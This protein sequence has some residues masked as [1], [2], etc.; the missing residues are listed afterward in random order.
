MRLQPPMDLAGQRIA[1]NICYEDLFGAEIIEAWHDPRRAPTILL[2]LSNLAWFGDSIALPQHLHAS[3]M[4]ARETGRPVLRSTNTGA[5]AI[6][7]ARGRITGR[8][9]YNTADVLDGVVQG[10][11]GDTPFVRSGNLPAL[12]ATALLLVLAGWIGR[13]R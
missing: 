11:T 7:D 10:H 13:R 2:N 4:R 3:R 6:I 9:A 5:T 1:V 8:L 12:V